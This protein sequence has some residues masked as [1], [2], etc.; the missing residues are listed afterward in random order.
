MTLLI[1][2][3]VMNFLLLVGVIA[4]KIMVYPRALE[5]FKQTKAV[6]ARMEDSVLIARGSQQV[7]EHQRDQNTA[8][9]SKVVETAKK[10]EQTV[11]VV[12]AKMANDPPSVMVVTQSAAVAPASSS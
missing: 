4:W 1:A 3:S 10:V 7:A 2:M 11:E 8:V 5:M 9:L 6:M 12:V